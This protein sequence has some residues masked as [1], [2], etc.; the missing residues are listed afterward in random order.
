[1]PDQPGSRHH[2][3]AICDGGRHEEPSRDLA[4]RGAQRGA[5]GRRGGV[6]AQVRLL[7]P[8]PRLAVLAAL[9]VLGGPQRLPVR[10]PGAPEPQEGADAEVVAVRGDGQPVGFD[11]SGCQRLVGG[12]PVPGQAHEGAGDAH[13][14]WQGVPA[15]AEPAAAALARVGAARA[16]DVET[17]RGLERQGVLLGWQPGR[18]VGQQGLAEE[19]AT[20]P[21]LEQHTAVLA[22]E[23]LPR[24]SVPGVRGLYRARGGVRGPLLGLLPRRQH[25]WRP[26]KRPVEIHDL[27]GGLSNHGNRED[28]LRRGLRHRA[29]WLEGDW[30]GQTD[31]TYSAGL[32]L[33]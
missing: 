12:L 5:R 32:E 27:F 29:V 8:C 19:D 31:R 14:L 11:Y 9:G 10:M 7:V 33:K 20:A 2:L 30:L 6:E 15:G 28:P 24:G 1:M 18:V 26:G 25:L 17:G 23:V 13:P 21:D 16:S 22:D 4:S 3:A